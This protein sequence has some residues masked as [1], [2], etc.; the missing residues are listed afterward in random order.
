MDFFETIKVVCMGLGYWH[1]FQIEVD[2][3]SQIYLSSILIDL[4]G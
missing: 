4:L 3:V 1:L 2:V